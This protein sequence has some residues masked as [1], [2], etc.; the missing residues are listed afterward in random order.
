MTYVNLGISHRIALPEVLEKL[1]VPSAQRTRQHLPGR[2]YSTR[3]VT[4]WIASHSG[5]PASRNA[6]AP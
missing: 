1:A 6:A 4:G 5:M 3:P 2:R